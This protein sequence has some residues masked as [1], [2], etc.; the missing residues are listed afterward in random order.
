MVQLCAISCAKLSRDSIYMSQFACRALFEHARQTSGCRLSYGFAY[1]SRTHITNFTWMHHSEF[2]RVCFRFIHASTST[3]GRRAR[4]YMTPPSEYVQYCSVGLSCGGQLGPAGVSKP[5]PE[6]GGRRHCVDGS[7]S[8]ASPMYPI[9]R[10][11]YSS[12][13][14]SSWYSAAVYWCRGFVCMR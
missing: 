6:G 13:F 5:E 2:A 12:C 3:V 9:D 8:Y 11:R 4:W 1:V 10:W 7:R 14:F